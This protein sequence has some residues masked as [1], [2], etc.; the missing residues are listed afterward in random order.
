MT[1]E[2]SEKVLRNGAN[3]GSLVPEATQSGTLGA[4]ALERTQERWRAEAN[5]GILVRSR[6]S[7]MEIPVYTKFS[8]RFQLRATKRKGFGT[9]RSRMGLLDMAHFFEETAADG[10]SVEA[11]SWGSISLIYIYTI[12]AAASITK[13]MPL[14]GDLERAFGASPQS[15]GFAISLYFS[16]LPRG[17]H[18]WRRYYRQSGRP[19]IYYLHLHHC[20]RC[21]F[22]RLLCHVHVH[23]RCGAADRRCGVYR[24]HCRSPALLMATT[25][26]TRRIKA[27]SLY[28]TYIPTG[29]ALGLLLAAPFAENGHWRGIFALHGAI[30]AVAACC[31]GLLPKTPR[32]PASK[33]GLQIKELLAIFREVGPMRLSLSFSWISVVGL[34]TTTVLP[35]YLA[36]THPISITAASALVAFANIAWVVGGIVGGLLLSRKVGTSLLYL[37]MTVAGMV[38]G[39][40]L[41]SPWVSLLIAIA[42]LLVW[43]VAQ[44]T[45]LAVIMS[46]LPHV[47]RDPRQGGAASALMMQVMAVFGLFTP[48]LYLSILAQGKW[49]YFVALGLVGWMLSFVFLP[50]GTKASVS[51]TAVAAGK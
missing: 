4:L 21:E 33:A 39:F 23:G 44:G 48:A 5:G 18:D 25:S 16:P 8:G 51:A 45:G 24:D 40:L 10:T 30:F 42:A 20:R 12:V 34:G 6:E 35:R 47:V 31:C 29:G 19:G 43:V 41:Y 49:M 3:D 15:V 1:G 14:T 28:S 13:L 50:S 11:G 36:Q 2:V 17:R 27:M 9:C 7:K 26:G 22:C 46:L 32:I 37:I 38:S